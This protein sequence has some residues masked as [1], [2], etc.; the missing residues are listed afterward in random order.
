VQPVAA[1]KFWA[2][3]TFRPGMALND[4]GILTSSST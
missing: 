1:S 4:I 2:W 3:P